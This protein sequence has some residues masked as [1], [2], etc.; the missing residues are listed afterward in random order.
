MT[1]IAYLLGQ[2][3]ADGSFKGF[4]PAYA[5]NQVLP[6][7]AGRTF[8]DAPAAPVTRVAPAAT[9][10]PAPAG[11][12]TPAPLPPATGNSMGGSTSGPGMP[13]ALGLLALL[14]GATGLIAMRG[15]GKA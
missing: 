9:P 15:H 5:T 6:A 4:D 2:Q 14:A 8:C 1:P 10:S 13:I 7:L 11:T 12:A 3:N